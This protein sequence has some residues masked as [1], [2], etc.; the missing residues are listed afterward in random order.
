MWQQ[1]LAGGDIPERVCFHGALWAG[2]GG[3]VQ[4]SAAEENQDTG[5]HSG[6]W[7]LSLHW[8]G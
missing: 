7:S 3:L 4:A 8:K 5:R 1:Q 2:G 6:R